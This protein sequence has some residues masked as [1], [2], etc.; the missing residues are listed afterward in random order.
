MGIGNVFGSKKL[1][2]QLV[3]QT[4]FKLSQGGMCPKQIPL[5]PK[6]GLTIN[7][8]PALSGETDMNID[9]RYGGNPT[10]GNQ[11]SHA[12]EAGATKDDAATL[13]G[14]G[15]RQEGLVANFHIRGFH[16][17][18]KSDAL[19]NFRKP[20]RITKDGKLVGIIQSSRK[21]APQTQGGGDASR[22]NAFFMCG[23]RPRFPD[24]APVKFSERLNFKEK[25]LKI[26][27]K[28]GEDAGYTDM[29]AWAKM[30]RKE[31]TMKHKESWSVHL[32][33]EGGAGFEEEATFNFKPLNKGGKGVYSFA[34]A[35]S[36]VLAAPG[37]GLEDAVA[38]FGVEA[39]CGERHEMSLSEGM[40]PM[41]AV[42]CCIMY[43]NVLDEQKHAIQSGNLI[44]SAG[45]L[46]P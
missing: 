6:G 12:G 36:A 1:Q 8:P 10:V 45:A 42:G 29:Y 41:F 32:S 19:G 28:D 34:I 33:K 37:G 30:K 5:A 14:E 24:D 17:R 18:M 11:P 13:L 25:Y 16:T 3:P 46:G 38:A 44:A 7:F 2:G 21:S 26:P 43:T 20:T 40:C 39:E 9:V 35:N 27:A 23:S 31:A 22:S 15:D 4:A